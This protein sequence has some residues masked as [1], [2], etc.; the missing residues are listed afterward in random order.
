[1][2]ELRITRERELDN[3]QLNIDMSC[4]LYTSRSIIS[5]FFKYFLTLRFIY[6]HANIYSKSQRDGVSR[7]TRFLEK[8]SNVHNLLIQKALLK[9][10][11][12]NCYKLQERKKRGSFIYFV[13][14]YV[15]FE[16]FYQRQQITISRADLVNIS[17]TT[18][19]FLYKHTIP[20]YPRST[21]LSY[22]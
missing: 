8:V 16:Y 6:T 10:Y 3:T 4:T 7:K 18:F 11:K 13:I 1:M 9:E 21:T 12:K 20:L 2:Q 19:T 15:L 22:R 5:I 14:S 17:Q